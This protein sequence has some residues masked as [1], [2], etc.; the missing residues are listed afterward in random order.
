[1]F[2]SKTSLVI[3]IK[4]EL[5]KLNDDGRE[6]IL[7]WIPSHVGINGNEMADRKAKESLNQSRFK[8]LTYSYEDYKYIIKSDIQKQWQQEWDQFNSH[9][10]Q[11]K[12]KLGN[13]GSSFNKSRRNEIAICRLRLGCTLIDVKHFF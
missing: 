11:I 7:E 2:H 1:M 13:L 9:L 12:P 5:R 4:K 8:T 10:H 3:R 6:I